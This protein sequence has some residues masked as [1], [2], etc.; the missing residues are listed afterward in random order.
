MRSG[1]KY[2]FNIKASIKKIDSVNA[3]AADRKMKGTKAVATGKEVAPTTTLEALH[4]EHSGEWVNA[5]GKG[6]C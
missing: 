2:A 1:R 5:L 4:G 6:Y 3:M